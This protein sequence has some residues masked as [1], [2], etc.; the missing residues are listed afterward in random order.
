MRATAETGIHLQLFLRRSSKITRFPDCSCRSTFS[1][2]DIRPVSEG[3]I[4]RFFFWLGNF[5]PIFPSL[6]ARRRLFAFRR[7][8]NWFFLSARS[9]ERRRRRLQCSYLKCRRLSCHPAREASDNI[10][11]TRGPPLG[12]R[13][14][15]RRAR[16]R[17]RAVNEGSSRPRNLQTRDR[18]RSSI[19]FRCRSW[20]AP[21][22]T[23]ASSALIFPFDLLFQLTLRLARSPAPSR[24]Q[25]CL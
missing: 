22:T 13:C 19:S 20:L 1:Q 23:F 5:L 25:A 11:R 17:A 15:L 14:R 24:R 21:P 16:A 3:Q 10:L 12:R 2:C 6:F 4:L 8:V 7:S 18:P 9:E